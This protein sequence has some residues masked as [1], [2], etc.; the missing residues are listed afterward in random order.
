V[1]DI[2]S[3]RR[4][5]L[6]TLAVG[7]AAAGFPSRLLADEVDWLT[8]VTTPPAPLSAP[9]R[10]LAPLLVDSDSN[11]IT[12]RAAWEQHRPELVNRWQAFLGSFDE[13]RP[14]TKFRVLEEERVGDLIRTR[15]EYRSESGFDVPAYIVRPAA[16]PSGKGYPGIVALHPTTAETIKPIAGLSGPADKQS[17]VHLAQAG[18]VVLCP[19]NFLWQR[20][21]TLN[22]AVAQF[23]ARHPK[24]LG[25][26]KMIYD[27]R[28]AV[29]ILATLPGVD[30][31]R[32]GTFGHSLG[33]KEA[34]YLAAFD[35]RVKCG[36]SSEGGIAFD[37]TNW[38][39]PWYLGTEIDNPEF[40]LNHHQIL[41]LI[42]P[43]PFLV[44][45]GETGPGAADGDRSWPCLA[46]A[47]DVYRLYDPKPKLGLLNHGQGHSIPLPARQRAIAWLQ[48][49]C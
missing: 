18:F 14:K 43:R 7:C 24:S 32:I 5:F 22:D 9:K 28:Q 25:M 10:P 42:A 12:T 23:K 3:T 2:T 6:Q 26:S 46:A 37:S 29:D 33:A 48:A 8:E 44:L 11:P 13:S 15:I 36:V 30:P 40:P 39:A 47:Q 4:R 31:E 20:A 16:A 27:A 35:P 17:A 21:K 19:E 34:L 45:G 41:A 1:N 49:Y 38:N